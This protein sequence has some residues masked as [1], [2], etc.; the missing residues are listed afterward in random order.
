MLVRDVMT[1]P[2]VSVRPNTP[3]RA[4]AALLTERGFTALPVHPD[5]GGRRHRGRRAAAVGGLRRARAL[6]G[7]G[8]LRSGHPARPGR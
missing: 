1:S 8:R 2:V 4:A 5:Q 3:V 7:R 6:D